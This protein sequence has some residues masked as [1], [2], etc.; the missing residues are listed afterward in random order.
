MDSDCDYIYRPLVA[1]RPYCARQ[2]APVHSLDGSFNNRLD[3]FAVPTNSDT[4]LD[5]FAVPT[6][7]F[8]GPL[9]HAALPLYP[10][11]SSFFFPKRFGLSDSNHLSFSSAT[12]YHSKSRSLSQLGTVEHE[13]EWNRQGD[14][15]YRSQDATCR[16]RSRSRQKRPR[17]QRKS[18]SE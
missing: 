2:R 8:V 17:A 1:R 7:S 9:F 3:H 12:V 4:R 16:A 5:H 15:G 11:T 10:S 13:P 6:N 14:A 18:K